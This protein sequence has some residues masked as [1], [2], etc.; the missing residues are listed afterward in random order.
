MRD[1]ERA[2]VTTKKISRPTMYR[3][4][5]RLESEGKIQARPMP[6]HPPYNTYSVPERHH[7]VI[8]LLLQGNQFTRILG[9]MH[10]GVP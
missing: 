9:K 7:Q 8:K 5:K 1:M 4:K 3:Y 10:E 6:G 2:F